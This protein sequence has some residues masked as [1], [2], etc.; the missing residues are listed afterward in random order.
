MQW[1]WT[2]FQGHRSWPNQ[3][4]QGHSRSYFI[5]LYV[6]S[7]YFFSGWPFYECSIILVINPL[8]CCFKRLK[9]EHFLDLPKRVFILLYECITDKSFNF[10][11]RLCNLER[12]YICFA[13]YAI[14]LISQQNMFKFNHKTRKDKI[15][16]ETG[17][18]PNH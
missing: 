10:T 9:K 1:P 2:K 8:T 7:Y 16:T 13:C 18:L 11:S 14:H 6:V 4:G 5:T 12:V 3:I 15:T 17:W